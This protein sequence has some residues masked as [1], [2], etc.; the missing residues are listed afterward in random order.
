MGI[1][2]VLLGQGLQF[3]LSSDQ[4]SK[5]VCA[6]DSTNSSK[7]PCLLDNNPELPHNSTN[8][9]RSIELP[10]DFTHALLLY[11]GLA[12]AVLLLLVVAFRPKFKR[13]E[14]ERRATLLAKLQHDS[15]TPNTSLP[16]THT[17]RI[18]TKGNESSQSRI[19][20]VSTKL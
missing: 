14:M 10:K 9:D 8:L 6:A 17:E 5:S 19:S 3:N 1:V 11:D 2:L 18:A 7:L 20:S 13:L 16:S 12:V 4:L 15:T